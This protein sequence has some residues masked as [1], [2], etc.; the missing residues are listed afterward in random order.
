MLRISA[1]REAR[2]AVGPDLAYLG[3]RV[4]Q[5]G[6]FPETGKLLQVHQDLSRLSE[7]KAQESDGVVPSLVS[8][9]PETV[10]AAMMATSKVSNLRLLL[11]KNR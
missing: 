2:L 5:I 1:L 11:Q 4:P 8:T 3:K 9:T 6:D 10:Q 7:L